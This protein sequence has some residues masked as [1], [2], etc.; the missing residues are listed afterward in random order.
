MP[1]SLPLALTSVFSVFVDRN[2]I[3]SVL[4]LGCGFGK[5]G[6][7]SRE[8]FDAWHGRYEEKSWTTRIVGVEIFEKYIT[9]TQR[10]VYSDIIIDDALTYLKRSS[11]KF[12]VILCMDMIEHLTKERG[13]E[14]LNEMIGH[15]NKITFVS[16]PDGFVAQGSLY[17]N[18]HENHLCGWSR[19]EFEKVGYKTHLIR[20][21]ELKKI[22][23]HRGSA[24]FDQMKVEYYD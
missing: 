22:L 11:E 18:I 9:D 19:G 17:G 10:R 20:V 15:C 1:Y 5:Y 24:S 4:D 16:A 3:K 14:L 13:V 2:D 23:A 8:Y 21:G 6:Y 7:L 12:D